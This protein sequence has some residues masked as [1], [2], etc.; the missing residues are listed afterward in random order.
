M[1]KFHRQLS[2]HHS[3]KGQSDPPFLP[4]KELFCAGFPRDT[5]DCC[6]SLMHIDHQSV[7]ELKLREMRHLPGM[8]D[9]LKNIGNFHVSLPS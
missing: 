6:A 7:L 4:S 5:V 3:Y 9:H 1:F 2:C 8:P